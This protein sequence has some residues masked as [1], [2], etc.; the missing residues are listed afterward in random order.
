V[1]VKI[2]PEN[3]PDTIKHMEAASLELAPEYPF[4]YTFLDQGVAAMYDAEQR[5][6]KIFIYFA[7]LAIFISCLG[8]LGLSA[9]TAEQRTKEV[10]IRK[11]L[12]SSASGIV[13][14]LSRQFARWVLLANV[15]AWPLAYYAM[16]T[17]LQDFAYR[18]GLSFQLFLLA[19]LLSLLT[20]ALPVVILSLKAANADPV[21][22]L[23]YE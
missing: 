17:W 2:A 20:A 23:R 1:F 5:L 15:I 19:G 16:H 8:I 6:G 22:S 12:G 4:D 7:F 9:F 21:E 13:V 18:T 10:G 11:V 3:I 14:L